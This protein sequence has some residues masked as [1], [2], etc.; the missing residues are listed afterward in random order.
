MSNRFLLIYV[1]VAHL[2]V[3]IDAY[4]EGECAAFEF[5]FNSGA[6]V[7][8]RNKGVNEKCAPAVVWN[9]KDK[10]GKMLT[11]EVDISDKAF[12]VPDWGKTFLEERR[13]LSGK[14]IP[15]VRAYCASPGYHQIKT[16]SSEQA[17]EILGVIM[18][19][20]DPSTR[21]SIAKTVITYLRSLVG[22][23]YIDD[24]LFRADIDKLFNKE[25]V[26]SNACSASVQNVNTS[27]A[28]CSKYASIILLVEW[29]TAV[30]ECQ[31]PNP[32]D[33]KPVNNDSIE[34][35]VN[36]AA[37]VL[38]NEIRAVE[39]MINVSYTL[40]LIGIEAAKAAALVQLLNSYLDLVQ[41]AL[42]QLQEISTAEPDASTKIDAVVSGWETLIKA[43]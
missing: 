25:E 12:T 41:M 23:A 5:P 2:F 13:G 16:I 9:I 29:L 8:S 42:I 19:I 31:P 14:V 28:R 3:S 26:T 17:Q 40:G 37:S 34:H 6:G 4:T 36:S 10:V 39:K 27:L 38:H 43:R 1:S 15:D 11:K 35:D 32:Q 18:E 30:G 20:A 22:P 24:Q 7:E 33:K 21:F